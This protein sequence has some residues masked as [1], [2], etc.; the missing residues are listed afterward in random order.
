MAEIK[1]I[2]KV[3]YFQDKYHFVG[4]LRN[5]Y[6]FNLN[7]D[8]FFAVNGNEIAR[9]KIVGVELP[10][11]D[12]PECIYKVQLADDWGGKEDW[13]VGKVPQDRITLTCESI[14]NSI[15][16][17]KAS[18]IKNLEEKYALQKNEIERYFSQF[19]KSSK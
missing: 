3:N 11:T 4:T 8:V 6:K 16:D 5:E 19:D 9:G 14:F 12:N 17:A 13:F 1:G 18:A 10:P 2:Y 15:E 7:D